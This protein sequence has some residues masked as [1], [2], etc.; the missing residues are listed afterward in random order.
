MLPGLVVDR[1]GSMTDIPLR[2][3]TV[4]VSRS[5]DGRHATVVIAGKF[6]LVDVPDPDAMLTVLEQARTPQLD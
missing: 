1:S 2:Q 3:G 5:G 4:Q 6:A